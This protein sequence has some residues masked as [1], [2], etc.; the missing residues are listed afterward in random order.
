[1]EQVYNPYLPL[2]EYVPDGEP[3]V[4]VGRLYIFGSHDRA[5]GR[6]YC[7]QDYAVW[8]APVSDPRDWRF[9]GVSYRKEQDPSNANGTMQLWAPDVAQGPDGSS[10]SI[11]V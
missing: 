8:S 1:M 10:I 11:I 7:E 4:F 2:T 9:D 3:H 6:A 5:D